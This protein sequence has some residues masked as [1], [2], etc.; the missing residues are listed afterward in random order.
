MA[1]E[2]NELTLAEELIEDKMAND[3]AAETI[4]ENEEM[5][6][7]I[8]EIP[9]PKEK[10]EN[11]VKRFFDNLFKKRDPIEKT[12]ERDFEEVK[13]TLEEK[14]ETEERVEGKE[15]TEFE[16]QLP[17]EFEDILPEEE[18][19]VHLPEKFDEGEIFVEREIEDITNWDI[20]S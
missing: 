1:V 17:N 16:V 8:D 4:T 12:E 6:E 13:E 7:I 9:K 14:E 11:P 3:E 18:V 15:N 10:K 2:E 19:G 20:R 5:L